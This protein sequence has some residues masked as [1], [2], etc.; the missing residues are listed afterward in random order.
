MT[1]TDSFK[2]IWSE[3]AGKAVVGAGALLLFTT[4]AISSGANKPTTGPTTDSTETPLIE[5][6]SEPATTFDLSKG[7]NSSY[8]TMALESSVKENMVNATTGVHKSIASAT[9]K[10][11]EVKPIFN[12]TIR[13]LGAE[14]AENWRI[15]VD[16]DGDTWAGRTT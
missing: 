6:P 11:T 5:T 8:N 3:P 4:V 10:A 1:F 7:W 9:C 16:F 12:C 14:S 2:K 13:E 15:E